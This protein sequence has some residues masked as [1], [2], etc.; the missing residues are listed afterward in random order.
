MLLT[1]GTGSGYEILASTN[2]VDWVTAETNGPFNG[3][4]IF[5][6][7]TATNFNRWFYRARI[8]E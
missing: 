6:D 4:L 8:G 7:T 2:L 5:T 3:S 1:G